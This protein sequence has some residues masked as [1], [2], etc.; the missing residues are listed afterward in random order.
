MVSI[1]LFTLLITGVHTTEA[2]SADFNDVSKDGRYSEAVDYLIDERIAQ[3]LSENE[4]GIKDPIKRGD[5]MVMIANVL[6]LNVV[7]AP[8]TPFADLNYRVEPAVNATYAK[9]IVNG[10]TDT[11][12]KPAANITRAEMAKVIAN[13][14]QLDGE[15][16]QNEFID[17][18]SNWD[19]YIDALVQHGVTQGKT[20]TIFGTKEPV[21]RG[22]FALFIYRAKDANEAIG[23]PMFTYDGERTFTVAY[24]AD[25][26]LPE[27]TATDGAGGSAN[28][29][30][31]IT[32]NDNQV[33]SV[34]TEQ[35]GTYTVTYEAVSPTGNN[36]V[37][38]DITVTVLTPKYD[39]DDVKAIDKNTIA[40]V[41]SNK[42]EIEFDLD[43]ALVH[44]QNEVTVEYE[45]HEYNTMVEYDGLTPVV[46]A[47]EQS[48]AT[49][50]EAITLDD[51]DQVTTARSL[52]EEAIAMKEDVEIDGLS[53]LEDAEALIDYYENEQITLNETRYVL[54]T[55]EDLQLEASVTPENG[56][57]TTITWDSSDADVATVTSDGEVTAVNE[58]SATITVETE[59][60]TKATSTIIV[61]DEPLLEFHSYASITMNNVIQGF[62]T[63]FYNMDSRS[64]T[65]D[66]I[67]VYEGDQ[68]E[69]TYT[70]SS[71]EDDGFST[72][73]DPYESFGMSISYKY[74]GLWATEENVVKYYISDGEEEFEFLSIIE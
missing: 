58:G 35:P 43:Q 11:S 21:T 3:G 18:N 73:I 71:L 15:G 20:P 44:G 23:Y 39:I 24:G 13:A 56:P 28:I 57:S 53:K 17:V 72:T 8:S 10:K 41:F 49:L 30:K 42:E 2:S 70:Q 4:F 16:I 12:F 34:D 68:I 14:Y 1:G 51:K 69:S 67:E 74:G 22:E 66:K 55:G 31:T 38:M 27:V 46:E 59:S 63:S 48:I 6:D 64:V 36:A 54:R 19:T 65:I 60:G 25:F 37:I 61:S 29:T 9:E 26:D 45:D 50:P 5:A 33:E 32:Y 62:R 52:V 47:A 40:V 7:D